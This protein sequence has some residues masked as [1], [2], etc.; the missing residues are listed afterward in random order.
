MMKVLL[1]TPPNFSIKMLEEE[2]SNIKAGHS[3]FTRSVD[4]GI[5]IPLG[6][7]SLAAAARKAGY[8]D[9]E[10]YDVHR[11]FYICRETGYFLANSLTN[12]FDEYVGSKINGRQYDVI[13][14]SCLFNVQ[15]STSIEIIRQIRCNSSAK[16]VLGGNWPTNKY[17]DM[18]SEGIGDYLVLGEGEFEFIKLIQYI[19]NGGVTGGINKE[20]HIVDVNAGNTQSKG[21]C[22]IDDLDLLAEPAYDLLPFV[23]EYTEKSMHAGRMGGKVVNQIRSAAIMTTRG[24]PMQCTFCAAHGVHGRRIRSHSID[25]I[26][27]HIRGLVEN[28]DTNHLLFE[29]DMFNY[30]KQRTIELC[31]RLAEHLP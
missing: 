4:W 15:E 8:S 2:V 30:S 22:Q 27:D 24:C 11:Q 28:Y 3:D 23:E 31:E 17:P 18:V 14:L 21:S 5:A 26:V 12:F 29:D 1:I 10:I 20:K 6:L 13:G 7:L 19:D 25:Y 16:I 9:I